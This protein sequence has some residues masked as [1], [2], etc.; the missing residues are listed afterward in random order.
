MGIGSYRGGYFY[1]LTGSYTVSYAN[2]AVAGAINLTVLALLIW[3][4]RGRSGRPGRLQ[5]VAG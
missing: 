1:D 5:P 3:Y 4:R 2:A